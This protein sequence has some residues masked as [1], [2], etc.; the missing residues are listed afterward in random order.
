MVGAHLHV[1]HAAVRRLPLHTHSQLARLDALPLHGVLRLPE[2]ADSGVHQRRA[3]QVSRTDCVWVGGGGWGGVDPSR[4]SACD[5]MCRRLVKEER[6]GEEINTRDMSHHMMMRGMIVD[7]PWSIR[8]FETIGLSQKFALFKHK[9]AIMNAAFPESTKE[10][11]LIVFV[12]LL[13]GVRRRT[14]SSRRVS[15]VAP[16]SCRPR[17]C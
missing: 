11:R 4:S 9:F 14:P 6:E 2:Y 13:S 3:V 16:R 17:R 12:R 1:R 5:V 7:C 15:Q 8:T 10:Y